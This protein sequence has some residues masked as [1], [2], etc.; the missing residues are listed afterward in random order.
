MENSI[1][2]FALAAGFSLALAFTISSC[3]DDDDGGGWLSCKEFSELDHNCQD[4]IDACNGDEACEDRENKK[5]IDTAC[6]GTDEETCFEHYN[7]E[8]D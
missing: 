2:K 5:C 6:N 8:C 4:K 1:S 7:D 3:S